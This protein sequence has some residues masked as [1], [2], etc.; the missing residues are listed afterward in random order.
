[1]PVNDLASTLLK[2]AMNQL[3]AVVLSAPLKLVVPAAGALGATKSEY[4]RIRRSGKVAVT[5]IELTF[6]SAPL[7][8]AIV[9]PC[10]D[11]AVGDVEP[12][13]AIVISMLKSVLPKRIEEPL[14]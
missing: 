6:N 12:P 3:K 10:P 1:M 11:P 4:G 13:V 2:A 14:G 8:C 5:A 7:S 9:L